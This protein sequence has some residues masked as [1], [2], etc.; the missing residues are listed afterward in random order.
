[1]GYVQERLAAIRGES[2][3]PGPLQIAP[4][5]TIVRPRYLLR[6]TGNGLDSHIS[7]SDVEDIEIAEKMLAKIRRDLAR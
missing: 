5:P 4:L 1:M 3:T 2:L 6:F 7:I